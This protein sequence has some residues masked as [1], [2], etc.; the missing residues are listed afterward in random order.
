MKISKVISI[1]M[2]ITM[3]S[4]L[5]VHQRVEIIKT[6]YSLQESRK[7][8]AGLIDRNSKLMY[9]LSRLESPRYLLTSLSGEEIKF[10][11]HRR[12]QTDRYQFASA[13]VHTAG[14]GERFLGKVLDIFTSSAEAESRDQ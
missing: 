7:C 9:N 4:V 13:D 14:A 11:N 12:A 6:G 3:A 8:L 1:G 2:I 10:A 5:Y